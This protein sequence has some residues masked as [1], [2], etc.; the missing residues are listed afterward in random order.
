MTRQGRTE[1]GRGTVFRLDT[2]GEVTLVSLGSF[3]A[4]LRAAWSKT[5]TETCTASRAVI[6]LPPA[7]RSFGRPGEYKVLHRFNGSDGWAPQ[8]RLVRANDGKLYGTAYGGELAGGVVY[9]IDPAAII[10]LDEGRRGL[11]SVRRRNERAYLREGV[12]GR[13]FR[14]VRRHRPGGR[15]IGGVGLPRGPSSV[16]VV[17]RSGSGRRTCALAEA[18]DGSL[19]GATSTAERSQRRAVRMSRRLR[20]SP[21]VR[22][23]RSGDAAGGTLATCRISRSGL[24][25]PRGQRRLST[26]GCRSD[27][28]SPGPSS[29]ASLLALYDAIDPDAR[30][31]SP[32]A[33]FGRL[34]CAT[35]ARLLRHARSA[36]GPSPEGQARP[37]LRPAFGDRK[38]VRRRSWDSFA[39]AWIEDLARRD[40]AA[41]FGK[42]LLS[43]RAGHARR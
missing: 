36:R 28:R 14:L 7:A 11:G 41:G 3:D 21:S 18:S 5:R 4:R 6:P 34:R 42:E 26:P 17:G 23:A 27:A 38:R 39:A 24:R 2:Q 30:R 33:I 35:T 40:I 15:T 9:R 10:S 32:G 16:I 19:Y 25:H 22:P 8:A 20:A 31:S 43:G 13:S 12:P 1:D 29:R 37:A